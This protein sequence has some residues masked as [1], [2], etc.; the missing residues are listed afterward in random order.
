MKVVT[1]YHAKI[2]SIYVNW[3]CN[4]DITCDNGGSRVELEMT[5]DQAERL[6]ND[7]QTRLDRKRRERLEELKEELEDA[8]SAESDN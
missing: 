3:S 2:D 6:V 4:L 5:D 7:L 8:E 1:S